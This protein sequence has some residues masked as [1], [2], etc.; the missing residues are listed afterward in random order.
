MDLVIN[1]LFLAEFLLG[2]SMAEEEVETAAEAFF[3]EAKRLLRCIILGFVHSGLTDSDQ[4]HCSG[5]G[6]IW[7]SDHYSLYDFKTV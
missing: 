6:Q 2:L 4:K 7:N 1:A 3:S 5:H